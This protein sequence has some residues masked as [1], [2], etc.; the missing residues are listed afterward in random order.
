MTISR[1]RLAG[2]GSFLAC[3]AIAAPAIAQDD[4]ARIAALEQRV[5]E[6]EAGNAGPL[7]FGEDSTTQIEIYGYVKA[8][9]IFDLDTELG[10]TIFPLSTID[11]NNLTGE[12]FTATA[13]Q[14]RLG[15]RTT[16]A[17][18]YGDVETQIE[19]DFYG[20]GGGELRLRH[21]TVTWNGWRA[22][23]YWTTFMPIDS[24]PVTLDFQGVAGIPFLR[25]TQLRYTHEFGGNF[26]TEVAIEEAPFDSDGP[27][28]IGTVAYDTD[29]LLVRLSGVYGKIDDDEGEADAYG[30]NLSTTAS[31]WQGAELM[32][33]YTHGEGIAS[34]MVFVGPELDGDDDA[35]EVNAAYAGL[36]QEVNDQ[37]TLSA[38]YGWREN[39]SAPGGVGTERVKTIHLNALYSPV[40][41][42]TL[43]IE[44]LRG[45]RDTF[46]E[47]SADVDRI[48]ASVQ[49]A[50]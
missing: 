4:A 10:E 25:P 35:I 29:P 23:Q 45:T 39:G 18:P 17:T 5:A 9:L 37:L 1:L 2:Y 36:T 32:A 22:G 3:T 26:V 49:V 33:A 28:F 34:Y 13:N 21:A 11:V 20:G 48:Q 31:L 15:L 42:T 24:Y 40:E 47:G 19:T 16:T 12:E 8:D 43:G 27:A 46:T 50:F 7:T 14:T 30:F 6:L 41:N 44:Y 38:I